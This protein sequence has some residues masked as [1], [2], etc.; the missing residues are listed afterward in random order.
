MHKKVYSYF[1]KNNWRYDD[2]RV[3]FIDSFKVTSFL[4][5]LVFMQ[6]CFIVM[7]VKERE[8]AE[9]DTSHAGLYNPDS[10]DLSSPT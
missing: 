8:E 10:N 1:L 9:P 7:H 3:V 4:E 6:S 2:T 5:K